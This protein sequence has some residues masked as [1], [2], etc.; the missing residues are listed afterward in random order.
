V[1]DNLKVENAHSGVI[2]AVRIMVNNKYIQWGIL[3]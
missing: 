3:E 1:M 2:G